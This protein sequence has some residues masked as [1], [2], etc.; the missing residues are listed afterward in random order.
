MLR[1]MDPTPHVIMPRSWKMWLEVNL[2]SVGLRTLGVFQKTT[3]SLSHCK[4]V[5]FPTLIISFYSLW[6]NQIKGFVQDLCIH[7]YMMLMHGGFFL[8]SWVT[9]FTQF[10]NHILSNSQMSYQAVFANVSHIAPMNLTSKLCIIPCPMYMRINM[11][12]G[13]QGK[14]NHIWN[15]NNKKPNMRINIMHEG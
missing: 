1:G 5:C 7:D 9:R 14:G 2:I 12:T 3:W 11:G 8:N 6:R 4:F 15:Q 10:H 13:N